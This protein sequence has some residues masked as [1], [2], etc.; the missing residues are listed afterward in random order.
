MRAPQPSMPISSSPSVVAAGFPAA[1]FPVMAKQNRTPLVIIN[2]EETGLDGLADLVI[3]AEIGPVMAGVHGSESNQP[4]R[5]CGA[6]MHC[7]TATNEWRGA[8]AAGA[9]SAVRVSSR[10]R[11][12]Q[13][14]N[15]LLFS[16]FDRSMQAAARGMLRNLRALRAQVFHTARPCTNPQDLRRLLSGGGGT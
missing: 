10:T 9:A 4:E 8:H 3:N 13:C 2:R 15:C 12:R 11:S 16:A 1:G 14:V 6:V 7:N 5:E